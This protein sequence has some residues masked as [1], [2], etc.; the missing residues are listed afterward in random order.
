M[1]GGKYGSPGSWQQITDHVDFDGPNGCWVWR[2]SRAHNGYGTINWRYRPQVIHRLVWEL[3][4]DPIPKGMTLDHLCR[5]RAC[6]NPD[7]LE[8]VTNRENILRG[9]GFAAQNARKTHCPYGH[10]YAGDNLMF[11]KAGSRLCRTCLHRRQAEYR[12]RRK[13]A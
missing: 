3:T 5:N 12:E 10:P 11:Q 2:G 9:T 4:V 1:K 6:C 8:A 7:H 13:R